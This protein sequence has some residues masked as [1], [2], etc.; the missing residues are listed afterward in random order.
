MPKFLADHGSAP[1][2]I[3]GGDG[4]YLID[5]KGRRYLDFIGGWCTATVGWGRPEMADAIAKQARKGYYVPP[6]FRS[7]NQEALAE[8]LT[9]LAPGKLARVFRCT[10]GSE[11]VEFMLKCARAATG[12]PTV[13]SID[14]VYHGHTYGALAL[15]NEFSAKVGPKPDGYLKLAMP[16]TPEEGR[17]V[18]AEFEKLVLKRRDIAAFVSEPIWTNAGCHIPPEGFYAEIQRLCRKHG[19]LLCMDEVATGM[20][21]CGRLFA[22]ELWGL[23]PDMIALGKSFTGGYASMGATLV[24][25]KVF[26]KSRG[27]SSYS[28]FGWLEQDLAA[29]AK[30]VELIVAEKL[31]ENAASVGAFLLEELKPLEKLMKVKQVRGIGMV[32]AVEFRL[33]IAALV[34][35]KCYRAGLLVV[36]SDVNTLFFSP[37]LVLSRALARKGAR[38]IRRACGLKD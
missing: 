6:L 19:V 13:V 38:I 10:S 3:V 2:E 33:P 17:K 34:A 14:G 23:E 26:S 25:E 22:S 4:C 11:A 1:V 8:T 15:G 29:A 27:I 21:R 32:F 31:H 16:K 20:G 5:P 7:P 35:L 36:V 24:T 28:T 9:E 37:P 18:A 12:K 30:N